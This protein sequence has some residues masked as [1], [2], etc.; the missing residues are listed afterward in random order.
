MYFLKLVTLF[1]TNNFVQLRRKWLSLP[2]LLLFP[3]VLM[4]L[5]VF[6]I[7]H[8][9]S[10]LEDE[11]LQIGLVDLNQST[12]TEM[13]V[14][15]LE[16][17]SQLGDFVQMN[18]MTEN[19]ATQDIAHDELAAYIL[20]PE[21]FTTK[22]YNG[23][24]VVV[25]VVGNPKRPTESYFIKEL[26]D[27]AARHISSSQA[28][29]LTINH[30]TKQLELDSE[31]RNEIMLEQFNEFLLYAIGKDSI[32]DQNLRTNNASSSPKQYFGLAAGFFILTIW[33]VT[34]HHILFKESSSSIQ[35]RMTLYGVT[36]LQQ[37]IARLIVTFLITLFL[38]VLLFIGIIKI[39]NF[40]FNSDNYWRLTC[41]I[42]L[43]NLGFLLLLAVIDTIIKSYKVRLLVQIFLTI[44]TLFASGAL[45]PEIYFPLYIQDYLS[46]LF[47]YQAYNWLEE[48]LLNGRLYV[49][50]IPLLITTVSGFLF[51]LGI[52]SIKE[53]V[54][55]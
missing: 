36:G 4:G 43:Y 26:V 34:I 10:N 51:L 28:N 16:E 39:L 22:L 42:V 5:I 3:I 30:Y 19:E 11:P 1:T 55:S 37:T 50:F 33:I 53:R 8:F 48:I 17:S 23:Q 35:R 32:L 49:D 15:L 7:V 52:S 29:I 25:T 46:F 21:K 40:D 13:I 38:G 31:T 24:S 54:Q 2:L 27:S 47:S 20:F 12:E 18:R 41:L 9:F 14:S 6:I 45:I 44:V